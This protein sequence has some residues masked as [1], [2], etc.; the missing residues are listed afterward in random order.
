MEFFGPIWGL[1][2]KAIPFIWIDIEKEIRNLQSYI[3]KLDE[4]EIDNLII[5]SAK[6]N[7]NVIDFTNKTKYSD[8][9]KQLESV[10]SKID[11]KFFLSKKRKE[12]NV[13][14]IIVAIPNRLLWLTSIYC[15]THNSLKSIWNKYSHLVSLSPLLMYSPFEMGEMGENRFNDI[16]ADDKVEANKI[17]YM[18]HLIRLAYKFENE[19]GINIIKIKEW[20]RS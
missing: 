7:A 16:Y 10:L 6:K 4:D 19:L 8:F 2:Q 20:Q 1:I 18:D 3:D 5:L 9:F 17:Y 13:K 11:N 12:D 15:L 14:K